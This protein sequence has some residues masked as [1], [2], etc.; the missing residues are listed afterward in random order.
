[1]TIGIH[2]PLLYLT[3]IIHSFSS[4]PLIWTIYHFAR[5]LMLVIYEKSFYSVFQAD[6]D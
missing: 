2:T 1:M 5:L 6:W 4:H 3:S